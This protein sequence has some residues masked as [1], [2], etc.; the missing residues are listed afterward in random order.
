M[1][2]YSALKKKKHTQKNQPN[3]VSKSWKDVEEA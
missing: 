1:E 2:Y 3:C